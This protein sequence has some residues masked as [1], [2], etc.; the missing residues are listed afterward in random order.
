LNKR[1]LLS[2]TPTTSRES[3][4]SLKEEVDEVKSVVRTLPGAWQTTTYAIAVIMSLFHIWVNT[5][6]VMPGIYR[7]AVHMGFVLILVFFLYPISKRHPQRFIT[8]DVILSFLAAIV[9][10]YI[11]LFEEE[12]HLER[13]SIPI[14]RDYLFAALALILLLY[15][16]YRAVGWFIPSLSL[17]FCLFMP[18]FLETLS[19]EHSTTGVLP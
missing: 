10:I 15:G 9:A 6:G 7:N 18:S 13:A 1:N 16:T 4:N 8:L 14:L 2:S 11:L 12:L 19:P 5:F 3:D 17:L